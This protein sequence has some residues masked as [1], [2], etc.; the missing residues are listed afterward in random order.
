MLENNARHAAAIDRLPRSV[1]WVTKTR[2]GLPNNAMADLTYKNLQAVGAPIYPETRR[3]VRPRDPAQ[4]GLEPMDDPFIASVSQLTPPQEYEARMRASLPAWQKHLPPTTTMSS[5]AGTR[6][7]CAFSPPARGC[8]RRP[9]GYAYPAWTYNALGGLPAAIDPGMFVAAKTI[10][11]TLLDL[12][13]QPEVL[14]ARAGRVP[15]AHRRRR[16]RQGGSPRSAARLRPPVDL[17]WPEYVTTARGEEWCF[18]DAEP[19]DRRG[20]GT[21]TSRPAS[22]L[23]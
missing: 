6:R 18:P 4:L 1:R 12:A 5:T 8:A 22:R 11:L 16:R 2:V 20:G 13:T 21:L 17:R 3:G 23:V 19:R 9:P 14:A 15:R 10:A 7:R